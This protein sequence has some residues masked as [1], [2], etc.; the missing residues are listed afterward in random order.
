MFK[1]DYVLDDPENISFSFSHAYMQ[2]FF[3]AQVNNSNN[4]KI[5]LIFY[6]NVLKELPDNV[7]IYDYL[8]SGEMYHNVKDSDITYISVSKPIL[9]E[10]YLMACNTYSLASTHAN[11][12]LYKDFSISEF[13]SKM[14]EIDLPFVWYNYTNFD[15]PVILILINSIFNSENNSNQN[16]STSYNNTSPLVCSYLTYSSGDVNHI[17]DSYHFAN[18]INDYPSCSHESFKGKHIVCKY[19]GNFQNCSLHEDKSEILTQVSINHKN[20]NNSTVFSSRKF[21]HLDSTHSYAVY[22]DTKNFNVFNFN[23]PEDI[24]QEELNNYLSSILNHVTDNYKE[25]EFENITSNYLNSFPNKSFIA[26]VLD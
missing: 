12:P 15:H 20:T 22:N 3:S 14:Q 18:V 8:G 26:S 21:Y 11:L 6:L 13:S 19:F 7:L 25:D 16:Q 2:S 17:S 5:N 10:L 9:S 23:I 1:Y 24:E 4:N